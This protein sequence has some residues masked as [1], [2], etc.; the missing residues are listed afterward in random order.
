MHG[1]FRTKSGACPRL[2]GPTTGVLAIEDEETVARLARDKICLDVCPSSNLL[3]KV[4]PD[5]ASHPLRQRTGAGGAVV[6]HCHFLPAVLG[7]L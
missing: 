3:L 6:L 7:C 1:T 4:Y 2:G 5:V